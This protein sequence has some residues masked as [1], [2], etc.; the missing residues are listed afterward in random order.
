MKLVLNNKRINSIKILEKFNIEKIKIFTVELQKVDTQNVKKVKKID[1]K[2]LFKKNN[3][4][5]S[6]QKIDYNDCFSN[7]IISS[8]K[9]IIFEPIQKLEEVSNVINHMTTVYDKIQFDLFK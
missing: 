9:R 5:Q 2:Q 8:I 1:K 6:N 7:E 3:L 4:Y